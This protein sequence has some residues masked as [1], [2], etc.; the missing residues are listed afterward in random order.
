MLEAIVMAEKSLVDGH[1]LDSLNIEFD[2]LVS[3]SVLFSE[4]SDSRYVF[5]T[6]QR[7]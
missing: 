2:G 7:I 6:L 3:V 4:I 5:E 1:T